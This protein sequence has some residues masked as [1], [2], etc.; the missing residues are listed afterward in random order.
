MQSIY[1]KTS[2]SESPRLADSTVWSRRNAFLASIAFDF[3]APAAA[4]HIINEDSWDV[5]PLPEAGEKSPGKNRIYLGA[6]MEPAVSISTF[7]TGFTF[8]RKLL[9]FLIPHAM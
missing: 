7:T 8:R 1:R 3:C 6:R 9:G 5:P 4:R 2:K